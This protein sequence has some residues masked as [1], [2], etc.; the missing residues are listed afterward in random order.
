MNINKALEKIQALKIEN[1][2]LKNENENLKKEYKEFQD[3]LFKK[4]EEIKKLKPFRRWLAYGRLLWDLI[5]LIEE[6]IR[7]AT[8][9]A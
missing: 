9:T 2:I 1:D 7:K 3:E 8:K 4:V 5:T 6:G